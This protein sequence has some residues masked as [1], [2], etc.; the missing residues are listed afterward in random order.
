MRM[1]VPL[2]NSV[3]SFIL[4]DIDQFVC[5]PFTA[6]SR[7]DQQECIYSLT[8]PCDII[9]REPLFHW[10]ATEDGANIQGI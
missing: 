4:Y 2:D 3:S 6:C 1:S 10:A 7:G 5:S 9:S 8:L